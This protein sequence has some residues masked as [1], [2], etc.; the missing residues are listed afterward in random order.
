MRGYIFVVNL[1]HGATEPCGSFVKNL[2]VRVRILCGFLF[3]PL[4]PQLVPVGLMQACEI[5]ALT[6]TYT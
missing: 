2:R 4:W 3:G 5:L 6:L 1:L